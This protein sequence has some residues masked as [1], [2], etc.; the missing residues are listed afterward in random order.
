MRVEWASVPK[1]GRAVNEDLFVAFDNVVA[2]L[3]GASVPDS[4]PRCCDKDAAWYVTHLSAGLV[5][6]LAGHPA[7]MLGD[8]LAG[9]IARTTQEHRTDC[10]GGGVGPSAALA[11]VR[12]TS[13]S[14]DYLVLGDCTIVAR[15]LDHVDVVKDD[16]LSTVAPEIRTRIRQRLSNGGGYGHPDHRRD[17]A[18]LVEAQQSHLNARGGYWIAAD[19]PTAAKQA[20]TGSWPLEQLEIGILSDG[21]ARSVDVFAAYGGWDALLDGL[22]GSGPSRLIDA[23]RL[24]EA[25]DGEAPSSHERHRPTTQRLRT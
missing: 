16:R 5:A 11:L 9:A 24:L 17:V 18:A 14:V 7:K 20:V 2:V 13:E 8:G 3:D 6:E 1:P 10:S 22:R 23:V 4:L 21:A 15:T 12:W 25:A 19:D